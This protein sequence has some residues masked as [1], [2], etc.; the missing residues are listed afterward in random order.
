MRAFEAFKDDNDR[1]LD[2]IEKRGAADV[3]TED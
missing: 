2:E 3:V 1:R